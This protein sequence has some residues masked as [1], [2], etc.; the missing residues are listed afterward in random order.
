VDVFDEMLVITW[1]LNG[2][3]LARCV[4]ASEDI[5]VAAWA[6]N[7]LFSMGRCVG[8]L[9]EECELETIF[10]LKGFP[11]TVCDAIFPFKG[12]KLPRP[13]AGDSSAGNGS[14]PIAKVKEGLALRLRLDLWE[15]PSVN[16]SFPLAT[17]PCP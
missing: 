4:V 13:T 17:K 3:E 1:L 5:L 9:F 15:V 6:L 12:C 10:W 8:K 11:M 16:K 2:F 7:G 14:S